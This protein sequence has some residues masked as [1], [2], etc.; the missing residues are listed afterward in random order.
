MTDKQLE[1]LTA[2]AYEVG[3]KE[4]RKINP[5]DYHKKFKEIPMASRAGFKALVKWV[6]DQK[7]KK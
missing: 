7:E 2:R 6:I 5:D 1:Q 4:A 3:R